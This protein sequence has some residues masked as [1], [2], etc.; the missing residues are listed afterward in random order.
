MNEAEAVVSYD[1]ELL[2]QAMILPPPLVRVTEPLDNTNDQLP[3][4]IV[5]DESGRQFKKYIT[6]VGLNGHLLE[7]AFVMYNSTLKAILSSRVL[8]LYNGNTMRF[9]DIEL[10]RPC[11]VLGNNKQVFILPQ[12][13]RDNALTYAASFYGTGTEYDTQG[14]VVSVKKGVHLGR[15]PA[16]VGSL[17]CNLY[18][19]TAEEIQEAGEDIN[20]PMCYCIINGQ[21]RVAVIQERQCE[22]KIL[23]IPTTGKDTFNAMMTCS[24]G[25]GTSLIALRISDFRTIRVQMRLFGHSSIQNALP[26]Y[27]IFQLLGSTPEK[28]MSPKDIATLILQFAKPETAQKVAAF[29]TISEFEYSSIGDIVD[30]IWSKWDLPT[31]SPDGKPHPAVKSRPRVRRRKAASEK[32]AEAQALETAQNTV[33]IDIPWEEKRKWIVAEM[34]RELFTH[35]NNDTKALK[36]Q[37]LAMM[38]AQLAETQLRIRPPHD[39]DDWAKKRMISGPKSIETLAKTIWNKIM[40]LTQMNIDD[41]KIVNPNIALAHM[42]VHYMIEEMSHSFTTPYWGA[43]PWQGQAV[44]TENVSEIV[45]R[46]NYVSTAAIFRKINTPASRKAKTLA[47]RMVHISQ[48]GYVCYVDVPEGENCGLVKYA[49]TGCFISVDRHMALIELSLEGHLS[50]IKNITHSSPLILNG[51]FMGWCEGSTIKKMLIDGRRN[52]ELYKDMS[53]VLDGDN[54]LNVYCDASRPTRPLLIVNQETERL[55]IDEKNMWG[56]PFDVLLREGCV[57]YIDASEQSKEYSYVSS[58]IENIEK[59][60]KNINS[61]SQSLKDIE[62]DIKRVKN[63]ERLVRNV[64]T[65]DGFE[66]GVVV[67]MDQLLAEKDQLETNF[68]RE[69]RRRKFTHCEIDPSAV[70]SVP[71]SIIPLPNH[72]QAPRNVYQAS[73][74]KQAT[75]VY[76]TNHL[77]RFDSARILAYPS[78]P[79][80]EPQM[81]ALLGMNKAPSGFNVVVA[82]SAQKE[83]VEDAFIVNKTAG[84]NGMGAYTKNSSYKAA[85]Q[86]TDTVIDVFTRPPLHKGDNESRYAHIGENGLPKLGAKLNP[87]DC[88]VGIVRTFSVDR[89]KENVSLYMG[90]GEH[91]VVDKVFEGRNEAGQEFIRVKI[92]DFRML[93]IGDKLASRHAQK[94]TI[95]MVVPTENMPHIQSEKKFYETLDIEMARKTID[96]ARKIKNERMKVLNSLIEKYSQT[97]V[98]KPKKKSSKS[99]KETYDEVLNKFMLETY[100]LLSRGWY[101]MFSTAERQDE[102][103]RIWYYHYHKK[104]IYPTKEVLA[105]WAKSGNFE[106]EIKA[107]K[108][109]I[110]M[111]LVEWLKELKELDETQVEIE[112]QE[113]E[114]MLD[115]YKNA[116]ETNLRENLMKSK[117]TFDGVVPSIIINPHAIPSRMT[118]AKMIEFIAGTVSALTGTFI[119]ASAFREVDMDDFERILVLNGIE[120]NG[121]VTMYDGISGKRFDT[122]VFVGMPHYQL[123]R[124][125]VAD[126]YQARG[127]DGKRTKD[128]RQPVGGRKEAGGGRQ[129]EMERDAMISVG[130]AASISERM[131]LLSDATETIYC[132]NCSTA[133]TNT[134]LTENTKCRNCG[135]AGKFGKVVLP[136]SQKII[137][138]MLAA[139][140]INM[141]IT[142][143]PKTTKT[144]H[145]YVSRNKESVSLDEANLQNEE[146]NEEEENEEGILVEDGD[147]LD[148]GVDNDDYGGGGEE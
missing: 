44:L 127:G 29:L 56:Q 60:Q 70:F 99:T 1:K 67:T 107:D 9:S 25:I 27:S 3:G 119:N 140:G 23:I 126:K 87:G 32:D 33:M 12:E 95:G 128:T 68:L 61:L 138:N 5:L 36:L 82:I 11:R 90:V 38:A 83:N 135:V 147:E 146:E 94:G 115:L 120:R 17:A 53:V 76:H 93:E 125:T 34:Q 69:T 16:L 101:E 118:M 54:I 122:A 86:N 73:M 39:R 123:L 59:R 47:I 66:A 62:T 129:G 79:A 130:G 104:I 20:D 81:N 30:Y 77:N 8:K 58:S 65:D 91:G 110:T 117:S 13:A 143:V 31:S 41:K 21:E 42:P 50:P 142:A 103:Y 112:R 84:D 15:M 111:P 141:K 14:N 74:G 64:I 97:N 105:D 89:S 92:R 10:I 121:M 71:V 144:Q 85:L 55:V 45:P 136:Y 7:Q 6:Y 48:L 96:N 43:R 113:E 24:N 51:R 106:D 57:E 28:P 22:N 131:C 75:G 52:G 100:N 80:A 124:H 37:L 132:K 98:E 78:R 116:E 133:I 139:F 102:I 40:D 108:I 134:R 49:A 46:F 18:E 4:E 35:M 148:F 88:I 2:K 26:L 137:T 145:R 63:G 109:G 72:N 114:R 19:K